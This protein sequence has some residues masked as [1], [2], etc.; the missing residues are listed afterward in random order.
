LPGLLLGLAWYLR[1]RDEVTHWELH[2][3]AVLIG[4]NLLHLLPFG[5]FDGGRMLRLVLF[6]R[7][8]WIESFIQLATALAFAALAYFLGSHF[9][10]AFAAVT[11][12]GVPFRFRKG[13]MI[14]RLRRDGLEMPD[15]IS[16]LT[17]LQGRMLFAAAYDVLKNRVVPDP[18]M[19]AT[20]REL[21][22]RVLVPPPGLLGTV[23]ILLLFFATFCLGVVTPALI[24][25]DIDN[26][27]RELDNFGANH[28]RQAW[29]AAR[30]RRLANQLQGQA[31]DEALH[32]VAQMEQAIRDKHVTLRRKLD[33][34]HSLFPI[35]N[36][37]NDPF[38]QPDN[39]NPPQEIGKNP[40]GW[41][42]R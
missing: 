8:A 5:M 30:Q 25:Y 37:P 40:P 14:A 2:L 1:V 18:I 27:C 3:I 42:V 28:L 13:Q 6:S 31:K 35:G 41:R 22:D 23:A 17:T 38:G 39:D 21:H 34:F 11:A 15:T 19:A 26:L 29:E 20:M 7:N 33:T 4:L 24:G 32:R 36:A 12:L 10:W 16:E 9:L